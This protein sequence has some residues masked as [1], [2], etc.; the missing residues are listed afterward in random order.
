MRCLA[1]IGE[2]NEFEPRLVWE[3]L[4]PIIGEFRGVQIGREGS[5]VI[6][7]W[8]PYWE[9][10][11]MKYGNKRPKDKDEGLSHEEIEELKRRAIKALR[12]AKADEAEEVKYVLEDGETVVLFD[13]VRGW[14]D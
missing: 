12:E 9:W 3:K 5:P 14:W 11:K 1:A 8:L 13:V 4:K 10:Q 7:L 6:Y 2:Y